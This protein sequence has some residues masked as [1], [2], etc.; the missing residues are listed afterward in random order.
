MHP[1][2]FASSNLN[3]TG[4]V[5]AVYP[6]LLYKSLR[7]HLK[8][9]PPRM[10]AVDVRVHETKITTEELYALEV[11]LNESNGHEYVGWIL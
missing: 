5:S 7:S 4:L 9:A 8:I 1:S 3:I 6:A 2:K 10:T 11:A